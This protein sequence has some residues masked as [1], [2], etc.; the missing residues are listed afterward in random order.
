MGAERIPAAEPLSSVHSTSEFDCGVESLNHYL[1]HR[2]LADQSAGKSRSYVIARAGRVR[3]YFSLAA[4]SIEP[5]D[6][7]LRAAKGQGGH[8][9]PA[10]LLGRLAVDSVEQ[11]RGLGEALLLEVLMK[12]AAAAQ[13]IGAR[14]VLVH[15]IDEAARSFY[16][17]YG[18]EQ[19]PTHPL[20]LMMLMKDIR[21]SLGL[22]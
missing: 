13:T 5:E 4:G 20:H 1:T 19:S 22:D 17:A 2:A 10:I 14:V 15:A 16:L 7:T 9:V 8:P 6:A 18:F 3:G 21:K 12:A 11:G